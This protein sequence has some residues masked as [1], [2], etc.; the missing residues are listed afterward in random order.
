[1]RIRGQ[2]AITRFKVVFVKVNVLRTLRWSIHQNDGQAMQQND[3][4]SV[5]RNMWI[6]QTK[7]F[8]SGSSI[9]LQ[10]QSPSGVSNGQ[11]HKR[12]PVFPVAVEGPFL[13]N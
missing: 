11:A 1:M 2:P 12:Q 13:K 9:S 5:C 6:L 4:G 3:A 10:C 7:D 8:A